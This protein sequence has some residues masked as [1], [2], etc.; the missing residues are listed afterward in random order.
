MTRKLKAPVT[1]HSFKK[2]YELSCVKCGRT[3]DIYGYRVYKQALKDKT[4]LCV[5]CNNKPKG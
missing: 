1:Q 4:A 5:T 3:F 2:W